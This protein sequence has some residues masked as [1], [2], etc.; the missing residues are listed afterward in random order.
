M[1]QTFSYNLRLIVVVD[2][3]NNFKIPQI[4]CQSDEFIEEIDDLIS[5]TD[6]LDVT[7]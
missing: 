7:S 6:K 3:V 2:V 5:W 1:L 4:D